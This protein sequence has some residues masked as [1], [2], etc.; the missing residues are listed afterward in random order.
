[1]NDRD[2]EKESQITFQMPRGKKWKKDKSFSI[3]KFQFG[4]S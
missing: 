2:R 1:M 3:K 4:R